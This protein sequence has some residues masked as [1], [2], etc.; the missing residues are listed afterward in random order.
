MKS[1][2]ILIPR[3]IFRSTNTISFKFI[4]KL[5]YVLTHLYP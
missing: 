1:Y 2:L 4:F 5:F 3:S